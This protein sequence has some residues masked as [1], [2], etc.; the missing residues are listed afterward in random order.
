MGLENKKFG[1]IGAGNMASAIIAGLLKAQVVDRSNFIASTKSVESAKK[2]KDRFSIECINDNKTVANTADILFLCVKPYMIE[3]IVN[4]I[5]K[6]IKKET[7]IISVLASVSVEKLM[8]CFP[9]NNIIRVMPNTS[10][11]IC[12]GVTSIVQDKTTDI[13]SLK[14][15]EDIFK[16]LGSA[17]IIEES[18]IH[19][20]N[21]IAG[22]GP[23]YVYKLIDAF[24]EAGTLS[25]IPKKLAIEIAAKVFNGASSTVLETG[26]HPSI[27]KD[28]ICTPAGITIKGIREFE[29]NN[30]TSGVIETIYAAYSASVQSEKNI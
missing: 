21:A 4:E 5:N 25:G 29:A 20:Y 2:A 16:K 1:F 22:C 7:I 28:S 14:I 3:D 6:S 8:G 30:V 10:S 12:L 11:E 24:A 23:A 9:N 13:N 27:L 15:V 17:Y 19:A 26:S 18:K